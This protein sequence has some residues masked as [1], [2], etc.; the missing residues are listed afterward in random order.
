V[1]RERL[2]RLDALGED[3]AKARKALERWIALFE[4]AVEAAEPPTLEELV[5][6]GWQK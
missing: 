5:V 4:A 6:K 3:A 1:L 2:P